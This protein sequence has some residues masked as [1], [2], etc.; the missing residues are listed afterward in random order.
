MIPSEISGT[1]DP[2][3]Y[4]TWGNVTWEAGEVGFLD[5]LKLRGI[6]SW[7]EQSLRF[8]EDPDSTQDSIVVLSALGDGGD[9]DGDPR[10]GRQISLEGQVHG[11]A[12]DERAVFVG[13][14]FAQWEK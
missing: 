14:V 13:G 7:R 9:L 2:K 6:A 5:D 11:R 8:E 4:G 1:S 12:L 10:E 3:A